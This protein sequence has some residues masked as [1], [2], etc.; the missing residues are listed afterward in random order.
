[1]HEELR[2]KAEAAKAAARAAARVA[3]IDAMHE[4][5]AP[6]FEMPKRTGNAEVDSAADLSAVMT[7]FRSRMRNEAERRE[8][9]TDSEHWAAVC[10]DTR[11]QRDAF[12]V[13]LGAADCGYGM[14][15]FD[16]IEIANRLGID[17]PPASLSLPLGRIN[18]TWLEFVAHHERTKLCEA[19]PGSCEPCSA[20]F[21]A[22][23][24]PAAVDEG[25]EHAETVLRDAP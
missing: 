9:V 20:T 6:V 23:L 21:S 22:S 17:L 15:Y 18:P 25:A 10:F 4:K 3:R 1:M 14:R 11:A 8:L 2:S 16:G 5:T 13:A 7:A 19:D 24:E 12:F